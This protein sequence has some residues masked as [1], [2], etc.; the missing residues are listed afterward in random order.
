[1]ELNCVQYQI[2][3]CIEIGCDFN[4]I[5]WMSLYL[6]LESLERNQ[7]RFEFG[8]T[9]A[10]NCYLLA[11]ST[12]VTP[13]SRIDDRT[14]QQSLAGGGARANWKAAR[15]SLALVRPSS[16]A[17]ARPSSSAPARSVKGAGG[18][19]RLLVRSAAVSSLSGVSAEEA[20]GAVEGSRGAQWRELEWPADCSR[21]GH[22]R[23]PEGAS[24]E[25]PM[26]RE[27]G[28]VEGGGTEGDDWCG[29]IPKG[30]T[31]RETSGVEGAVRRWL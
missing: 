18:A 13:W 5:V 27:T 22:W 15:P 16:P 7:F 1:M 26:R 20:R 8:C 29:G 31:W 23:D 6:S 10:S 25:G 28:G 11:S 19:V 17:L 9:Q 14:H 3:H 24:A 12:L 30:T 4:Y 21:G 2:S